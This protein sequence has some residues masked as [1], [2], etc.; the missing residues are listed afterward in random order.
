MLR[1]PKSAPGRGR[2]GTEAGGRG[3][4]AAQLW[5]EQQ[6]GQCGDGREVGEEG[7]G[8]TS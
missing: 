4:G 3:R 1:L 2:A 5:Q 6:A 7:G 8:Q